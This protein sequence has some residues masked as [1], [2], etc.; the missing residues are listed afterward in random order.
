MRTLIVA[1][2]FLLW[3][4]CAITPVYAQHRVQPSGWKAG[5]DTGT[6]L[7]PG[8]KNT[9]AADGTVKQSPDSITITSKG[10]ANAAVDLETNLPKGMNDTANLNFKDTDLRDIF[11]ALSLEHGLNIF[12]DNS[13]NKRITIALTGVPVIDAVK[14][15]AEQN[16]LL[17]ER[18]GGIIKVLPPPPPRVEPPPPPKVPVVD[19]NDGLVSVKLKDDDLERV[20]LELQKKSGY[21]ILIMN[22]TTGTITGT[23]SWIAF[24]VGFTQLMNNNGFAVQ[25]KNGIYL[26]SR[27]DYFVGAQSQ[28]NGGQAQPQ[29]PY[30]VSVRDSLVT[31]DVTN[32]P[33]ARILPDIVRQLNTDVV[34]YSTPEGNITI[35]AANITLDRALD[36]I[37][38]N[39]NYTY[40]ISDRLYFIGEKTN[41]SLTAEK[42]LRLNYLKPETVMDMIPQSITSQAVIKPIKEHN[43]VVIISSNDVIDQLKDFLAQVDKPVAEILIEALVVDYDVSNSSDFG[44]QAGLL[45][46]ADTTGVERQ[47]QL[48]PGIDLQGNGTWLSRNLRKL[49]TFNLLGKTIDMG[50]IGTLPGD[51]YIHLKALE[52]RGIANVKSRPLLATLN[53]HQASLSI[54][55][56][57]YYLL[58][59]TTPYRDNTQVLFQESQSFQ[60]ID[61]DVKLDITPYVGSDSM[62][63]VEIKPDFKTPV[64][65]LSS[66][67]PP[68]INRR[69]LSSTIVVKEGETIVLGGLIQEGVDEQKSQVPILGSIPLLGGLFS[70]STKTNRKTELLIYVTPHISYGEP[71]QQVEI[72][73]LSR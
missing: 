15:M 65:T 42:L 37:L 13:I 17:L 47:G 52:Q 18:E 33:I 24:D 73:D 35:R 51:F 60:T 54:G 63:T 61:A 69:A 62:I 19:F 58:K 40:K 34:F 57:Q 70:S 71:F 11:R 9:G 25:K 28:G 72:P 10:F 64:G 56:T 55:T 6:V 7:Q 44:I 14:F 36:M 38:R 59:T 48:F 68:T 43:G 49:G 29:G 50:N 8:R 66:D 3:C 23:L 32:A 39:T 53:G 4:S 27:L 45:G 41:K 31:I 16:G 30:W 26:V 5:L 46:K 21:N 2:S 20:V 12:F 22:G 67:V 1:A